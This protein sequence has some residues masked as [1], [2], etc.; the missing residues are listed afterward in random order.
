MPIKC[1]LQNHWRVGIVFVVLAAIMSLMS[2]KAP[3]PKE[4][5]LPGS[6]AVSPEPTVSPKLLFIPGL[7]PKLGS[8]VFSPDGKTVASAIADDSTIILWDAQTGETKQTLSGHGYPVVS[9]TFSPKGDI[10][11]SGSWDKTVKL[12][13]PQTGEVV[14]TLKRTK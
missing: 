11:A 12:W 10:V 5:Q 4:Q 1:C 2:C 14:R 13:N 3:P 7:S 6:S 8:V 9:V